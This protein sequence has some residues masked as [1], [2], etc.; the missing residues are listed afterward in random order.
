MKYLNE[1][2][3]KE[4]VD[5]L[6]KGIDRLMADIDR[7]ITLMEVCGTHTMAV[8][9]YGIKDLFPSSL[10]LLSGP[11]CPVCVTAN[12]Y[13]DRATAY[14][15]QE[16]VIIA[17]FG[18]MMKVPG[19]RSS[20][21]EEA[22]NGAEIRVVYS[23]LEA[24]KIAHQNPEKKVVFLGIGFETTA[25]TVASSILTAAEDKLSNYFVL[26]GHK[27]MPPVMRTLAQ[28]HELKID[29]FICPGHVSTITG[30]KIYEFLSRDYR[31]PCVVAG[32]EPI[33]ILQSIYLILSQ[34]KSGEAKV[35][36]EYN[37]AV[38]WEGNL[39]AQA[40]MGEV[41]KPESSNWRGMGEI[42][43]SGLKIRD[44]YENFD[45]EKRYPVS[46]EEPRENPGCICGDILRGLKTPLDCRLFRTICHPS[47]PVGACMV[48][49]E[50]TCAAYYKYSSA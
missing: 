23:C 40:L 6:T 44:K 5:K 7:K 28:A 12:D 36:N 50:G 26:S 48:S 22:S 18:D 39:K 20:L 35:E 10:F 17:T 11:G 33:D 45:V 25:P 14:A 37:R 30:S 24:L 8:F 27:I 1:F 21:A 9:R 31:I 42:E 32:F 38:T 47:H 15:R 41:F 29:G 3:R 13:L 16:R 19:S 34:I 49:A 43:Q 4:L 46:I 2:R